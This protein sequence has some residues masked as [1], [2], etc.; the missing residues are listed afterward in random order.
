[1]GTLGRRVRQRTDRAHRLRDDM[2]QWVYRHGR[3]DV[4][5]SVLTSMVLGLI[6]GCAG[7]AVY[8]ETAL[9]APVPAPLR[10]V[11]AMASPPPSVD[12]S[13]PSPP[14]PTQ[15]PAIPEIPS[16]VI[17]AQ[18]EAPGQPGQAIVATS[19][20]AAPLDVVGLETRLRDTDAIGI[21]TKIALKNQVDDLLEQ[22]RTRHLDGTAGAIAALRQPYDL[23]VFKVLA[24][25]Q[26]R[27]PPLAR[28]IVDSREAIWVILADRDKF[29]L[30][31]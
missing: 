9:P 11:M 10:P 31:T 28:S 23:L 18:A 17:M 21:F 3:C 22:F 2:R 6:T 13:V 7:Q 14:S 12:T 16:D 29:N 24:L 20:R 8:G 5:R 19:P 27:D 30:A 26:D 1:M 4:K 15:P 25:L